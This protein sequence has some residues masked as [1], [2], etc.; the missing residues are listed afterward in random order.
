MTLNSTS[1]SVKWRPAKWLLIA[2]LLV[3]PALA[4]QD[5]TEF[6]AFL[7]TLEGAQVV[8][9]TPVDWEWLLD[10]L[11]DLAPADTAAVQQ[12]ESNNE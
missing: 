4:N 8:E 6:L 12:E 10:D 7:G 2:C 11:A 1:G 3:S 5:E 9:Q